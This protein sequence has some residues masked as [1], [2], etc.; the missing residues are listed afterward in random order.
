MSTSCF[1]HAFPDARV[2]LARVETALART[3]AENNLALGTLESIARGEL[4]PGPEALF[5]AVEISG[6]GGP[7]PQL[8]A[9]VRAGNDR[10]A[11]S[12]ADDASI[13]ALVAHLRRAGVMLS[14]VRAVNETADAFADRWSALTGLRS[15]VA[16]RQRIYQTSRVIAPPPIAGF[17]R[18]A[19][20]DDVPFVAECI[21]GFDREASVSG[22]APAASE[23]MAAERT[24]AGTIWVWDDGRPVAMAART[25]RTKTGECVSL[26]YTPAASRKKGYATALVAALTGAMLAEGHAFVCLFTDL[27]NPTSNAIYQRIGYEPVADAQIV[28]F[29]TP[30]S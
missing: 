23:A 26:V 15:S 14:G 28:S 17:A 30:A 3:E 19:T 22:R 21:I 12:R 5:L 25:R 29:V 9:A 2:L 1:V 20:M 10:L 27:A 18:P 7:L 11:L 16:M 6:D 13:D 4:R 24:A 8:V